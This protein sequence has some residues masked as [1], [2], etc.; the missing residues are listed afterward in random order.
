MRPSST[1]LLLI[2]ACG[3]VATT[4]ARAGTP[5][6]LP[7]S[8]ATT[9]HEGSR[10]ISPK[11]EPARWLIATV[12]HSIGLGDSRWRSD[13]AVVNLGDA[14][15]NLTVT[16]LGADGPVERTASLAANATVEWRDVL[17]SL[18]GYPDDASRAGSLHIASNTLLAITSR[19]YNQS[20]AGTYGQFLPALQPADA[21]LAGTSAVLPQLRNGS[22]F[23]TNIGLLNLGQSAA[24]GLVTL[25]ADNGQAAGTPFEIRAAAGAW[26]QAN[27][28]FRS[29]GAGDHE[30]AYATL[31]LTEGDAVWGYASV[32]D[33]ATRDPTT[34]PMAIGAPAAKRDGRHHQP[35]VTV[36]AWLPWA[37]SA[38][39]TLAGLELPPPGA[40]RSE[41]VARAEAA[42]THQAPQR[43][44]SVRRRGQPH[45]PAR[46]RPPAI[47]LATFVAP[48][49]AAPSALTLNESG[50]WIRLEPASAGTLKVVASEATATPNLGELLT[51]P[52]AIASGDLDGD[53]TPDMV[54][55]LSDRHEAA[56]VVGFGAT[57]PHGTLFEAAAGVTPPPGR[58]VGGLR[59]ADHLALADV[60]GDGNL[61][62]LLAATGGSMITVLPGT[63]DGG[64]S[65]ARR[66]DFDGELDAFAVGEVGRQDGR[67]DVAIAR[68]AEGRPELAVWH[69]RDGLDHEPSER[70]PLPERATQV[71][72]ASLVG[73]AAFD[74]VALAGRHLVITE[75]VLR[76]TTIGGP[77]PPAAADRTLRLEL[78][79][80]G[81]QLAVGDL[82]DRPGRELAVLGASGTVWILAPDGEV[83][84][85]A[86]SGV[87]AASARLLVTRV[88]T[89]ERDDL[90]LLDPARR[91]LLVVNLEGRVEHDELGAVV[92][93]VP[94]QPPL[95]LALRDDPV[96]LVA[97]RLNR[98]ALYD[99]V[100]ADR[101]GSPL[102][103]LESKLAAAFTV[104]DPGDAP[105]DDL[106]D[107]QCRTEAG[108][109]T[110]RAAFDEAARVDGGSTIGFAISRVAPITP[111]SASRPLTL[112]GGA[113]FVELDGSGSQ[114]N[115]P[116]LR[117]GDSS[118]HG[119]AAHSFGAY[120][121]GF[122]GANNVVTDCLLG[123]APDG[124]TPL[125]NATVGVQLSNTTAS[126]ASR[127]VFSSGSGSFSGGIELW[128]DG[129]VVTDNLFGV[130]ADG[131]TALPSGIGVEISGGTNHVVGGG[132]AGAGNVFSQLG[133]YVS[134]GGDGSVVQGNTFGLDATGAAPLNAD[135]SGLGL[136]LRGG[137]VTVGGAA[138]GL[139]N[140]IANVNTAVKILGC[141][142]CTAEGNVI[143]T[144]ADGGAQLAVGSG[145]TIG[146]GHSPAANTTIADNRIGPADFG[147]SISALLDD[148]TDTL[149]SHNRIGV[150]HNGTPF[151]PS[152]HPPV[153][154]SQSSGTISGVQIEGNILASSTSSGC[155]LSGDGLAGVTISENS[156]F[157]TAGPGIDLGR[158]GVTPNDGP[159]DPDTGPNG[160]QNYP[161]LTAVG[162]RVEGRLESVEV[163][164]YVVELFWSPE[165][166][167]PA[168]AAKEHLATIVTDTDAT[169]VASFTYDVPPSVRP[170]WVTATATDIEGSTSELSA[171]ERYTAE[172]S[173]PDITSMTPVVAPNT[174]ADPAYF[175]EPITVTIHGRELHEDPGTTVELVGGSG[176]PTVAVD[177]FF[178]CDD[179]GMCLGVAVSMTGFDGLDEGP[180]D[181][182]IRN[183]D[184][185]MDTL[186]GGF[187]ISSLVVGEIEVNQALP[188]VGQDCS[189]RQPCVANHH[190]IV[191]VPLT[192]H[193]TGCAANKTTTV[194][195]LHVTDAG[196]TPVAGSPFAPSVN[197]RSNRTAMTVAEDTARRRRSELIG[198]LD[199]LVYVFPES[200]GGALPPLDDG[201]YT[202]TFEIDPRQPD[203]LPVGSLDPAARIVRA[204][205]G[206][207]FQH[208][209]DSTAMRVAVLVSGNDPRRTALVSDA[210]RFLRRVYPLS[211][212]RVSTRVVPTTITFGDENQALADVSQWFTSQRS[213]GGTFTHAVFFSESLQ[214]AN[215]DGLSTCGLEGR[216]FTSY[217]CREPIILV[218]TGPLA[219]PNDRFLRTVAHEIGHTYLLGETYVND[220]GGGALNDTNSPDATCRELGGC[221]VEN[222]GLESLEWSVSLID[223]ANPTFLNG[224]LLDFMGNRGR[225]WVDRRTWNYLF[226][227]FMNGAAPGLRRKTAA[228]GP[229]VVVSGLVGAEDGGGVISSVIPHD[230]EPGLPL[231]LDGD[232]DV[233]FLDASGAELA[234][235]PFAPVTQPVDHAPVTA[236]WPF[237]LEVPWPQGVAAIVLRRDSAELDRRPVSAAPPTVEILSPDGGETLGGQVDIRW[238]AGDPDG[239]PLSFDVYYLP[240]SDELI[241]LATAITGTS[242]RWDTGLTP[243]AEGGRIRVVASDGVHQTADESD[244]P[245]AVADSPPSVAFTSPSDGVV[246]PAGTVLGLSLSA[247]DA[248]DGVLPGSALTVTSS[249][250]GDLGAGAELA[251]SLSNGLH[252]LTATANDSDSLQGTAQITVTVDA[253]VPPLSVVV[254]ADTTVGPPPLEVHFTVDASGG[255][256]PYRL[257]WDFGG[258]NRASGAAASHTF[259][260]LGSY[261]VLL[262]AQDAVGAVVVDT[263]LVVEV[264]PVD[265]DPA[266]IVPTVAHA[267][268]FE[269]SRWRSDV[270][271][272]SLAAEPVAVVLTF[273]GRGAPVARAFVLAPGATVQYRDVL[274]SLLGFADSD[275]VS[276]SLHV[277]TDGP[278]AV[279]SRTYNQSDAGTY[280][281]FLPAV[282]IGGPLAP[283]GVAVLP[284][285]R[286]DAGFYTNIGYVNTGEDDITL[287]VT[288]RDAAGAAIGSPLYPV[289]GAGAW[290]QSNDVF[291]GLG[292]VP[293][294][295]AEV[296]IV[297]GAGAA[298]AYASVVDRLTRDPTTIP[299]VR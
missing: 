49:A 247:W 243:G 52:V 210:T 275:S 173:M 96:D 267:I 242:H 224:A 298:W 263:S 216:F 223:P 162:T 279:A 219:A 299:M 87:V 59:P 150:D 125:P 106:N 258:G 143:G 208:S 26:R 138:P 203:Q 179:E 73:D 60:D 205:T 79:E 56:I 137:P 77:D 66:H 164:P 115:G 276:G 58:I 47:D 212:D 232:A 274:V 20:D 238:S 118:A 292:T 191:R 109:C 185:G 188:A 291:D 131:A 186:T 84:D 213:Q 273:M 67:P 41:V 149:V 235:H 280:G 159:G 278:V 184:G 75:G 74:V 43:Y 119:L 229:W 35:T 277:A 214:T 264:A 17:V 160:L 117:G 196:G 296:R 46:P 5:P 221:P 209:P 82:R 32:V 189:S 136:D 133:V 297:A 293:V 99:L 227:I 200:R 14:D 104:N 146:D 83:L 182:V 165:C 139:A 202:F 262:E 62:A 85:R 234:S 27:D 13:V 259:D 169:G 112:D 44:G 177:F 294:A 108:T 187:F 100:V 157:A 257:D 65:A 240:T 180:R 90:V 237:S 239:D 68:T 194:G 25:H 271:L 36:A 148:V 53:G 281:Q 28:V 101:Q 97:V 225:P 70:I 24:V 18:F 45:E 10:T 98:D 39:Q 175:S 135:R 76:R 256:P 30:V 153:N 236:E 215:D 285:L 69:G 92:T 286:G 114:Y 201:N 253:A 245:F 42:A 226:E 128:G 218:A 15:A 204:R 161:E 241:P 155:R 290:R 22:E 244:A 192:C 91:R 217:T 129:N 132:L 255:V 4:P 72:T 228:D 178:D 55:A 156:I 268:G 260:Q 231:P 282:A 126:T 249:R 130:A 171:C 33:R 195:R 64:F 120:G 295:Y 288:L 193:G 287:A 220:D 250:D 1:I 57:S 176:N 170:G 51:R 199:H 154:I 144:T 6:S 9:S 95:E 105:D 48:S 81:S 11:A 127:N 134:S 284:Q 21:L 147:V 248:D 166:G 140:V 254:S 167:E 289:L 80:P 71:A 63:G 123:L 86:D 283:G 12:A 111:V 103:V 265:V 93:T 168:R 116:N 151:P 2:A 158:D 61:D 197:P 102:T 8:T 269:E 270:A 222:G 230:A 16:F 181:V 172:T 7:A 29:A 142:G 50:P 19:T 88:S 124:V 78:P 34:I 233:A 23:Y 110:L 89:L 141:T 54:T 251:V 261:P 183:D 122:G 206:A 145:V 207:T 94:P 107:G 31:E 266:W 37:A 211:A 113:G 174:T 272:V 40:V 152:P 198:S 38:P 252:V 246:I 121:I 190:T 163:D 3:T